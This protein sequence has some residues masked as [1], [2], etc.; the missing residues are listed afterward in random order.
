[1]PVV[2]GRKRKPSIG[3]RLTSPNMTVWPSGLRRWLQARVRKGVGSNPTAVILFSCLIFALW[4]NIAVAFAF[5]G[6]QHKEKEE[7]A[8][9]KD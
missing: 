5:A 6:G 3:H 2:R 7:E 4:F 9:R 1:M 8:E